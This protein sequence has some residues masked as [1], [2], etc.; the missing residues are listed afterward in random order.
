MTIE[1]TPDELRRQL[2]PRKYRNVRVVVD[3]LPFASKAEARRY[4]DLKLLQQTGEISG[5]VLQPCYVL[6]DGYLD[7]PS[8]WVRPIVYVSDF[9]YRERGNTRIVV[10]DVKG[11]KGTQTAVFRL[12]ARLFRQKYPNL[13]FRIVEA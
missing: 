8:K 1:M 6:L 7:G 9:A 3:G 10:E 12:K 11:G 5:L 4:T 13:D 2:A